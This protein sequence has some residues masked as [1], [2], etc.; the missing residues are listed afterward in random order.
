MYIVKTDRFGTDFFF[1]HYLLGAF[2]RDTKMSQLSKLHN[3]ATRQE[4]TKFIYYSPQ[5]PVNHILGKMLIT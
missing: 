3:I 1:S 5:H 4:T 2:Q